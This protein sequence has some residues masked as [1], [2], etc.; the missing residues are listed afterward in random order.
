VRISLIFQLEETFWNL[1]IQYLQ[2]EVEFT[3]YIIYTPEVTG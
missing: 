3:Q 2:T 1:C